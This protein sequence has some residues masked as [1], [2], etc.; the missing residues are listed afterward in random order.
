MAYRV[1]E[2]AAKADISVDTVRYY[3]AKDLLPP[4]A[5]AG[6]V[7]WYDD[8]HLGR[9]AQIRRLQGRGF[10]LAVIRRLLN[11]EPDHAGEELG[12]ALTTGPEVAPGDSP[13]TATVSVSASASASASDDWLTLQELA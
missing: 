3:Q 13:A 11:G 1:E 8:E 12:A 6:R 7:A 4:P 10:S 9:L 5:R 2:L